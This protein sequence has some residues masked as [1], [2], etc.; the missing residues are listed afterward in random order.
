M[1][2][3]N[4]VIPKV[5]DRYTTRRVI[6]S[7]WIDG[8]RLSDST[9]KEIQD[10][11]PVGVELFLTQLLDIGVFHADPHP[12]NLLVTTVRSDGVLRPTA[13][14]KMDKS[15][16]SCVCWTLVCVQRFHHGIESQ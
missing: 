4:V 14:I 15:K 9:T 16:K 13:R 6:T 10:L 7:E 11:I 8:I 5:F 12:G 3:V 1:G 2:N